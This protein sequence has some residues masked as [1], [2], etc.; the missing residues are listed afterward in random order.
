MAQTCRVPEANLR[1]VALRPARTSLLLVIPI[2]LVLAIAWLLA[3]PT[4]SARGGTTTPTPTASTSPSSGTSPT[5]AP[6]ATASTVEWALK[7]HRQANRNRSRLDFVRTC[8]RSRAVAPLP[9]TPPRSASESRWAN[10]GHRCK[11][12]AGSYVRQR[13]RLFSRMR[14][15]PLAVGRYLAALRGWTGRQWAALVTLWSRESG[16]RTTA[17]NPSGAYGIPQALPG[18]KMRSAGPDWRSNPWT[19]IRWGRDYISGRYATPVNALA[20]SYRYGWY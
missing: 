20:H 11:H 10:Y 3:Q 13:A 5:A 4:P 18:C 14:Y 6:S 19:Q 15:H 1:T 8:L 12:L 2:V 7:W 9:A 16:W 17:R